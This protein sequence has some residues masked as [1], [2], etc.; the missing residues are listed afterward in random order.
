MG[1][2]DTKRRRYLSKSDFKTGRS[3]PTRL[4]F[5]NMIDKDKNDTPCNSVFFQ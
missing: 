1:C 2:E 5:R 3:C 4:Y